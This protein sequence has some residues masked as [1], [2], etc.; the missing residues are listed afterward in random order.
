VSAWVEELRARRDVA[1]E[2]LD[3]ARA[4]LG[5]AECTAQD[6]LE[7]AEEHRIAQQLALSELQQYEV[8][9][10]TKLAA[11]N[12]AYAHSLPAPPPSAPAVEPSPPVDESMLDVAPALA[13]A[14]NSY[15]PPAKLLVTSE[16]FA[17]PPSSVDTLAKRVAWSGLDGDDEDDDPRFNPDV[18]PAE[19]A[20]QRTSGSIRSRLS[21]YL[22]TKR[23]SFE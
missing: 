22:P 1:S 3:A 18:K 14:R 19:P 4:T 7:A 12:A 10:E 8:S 16:R 5:A 11:A 23:L 20:S 21:S 17:K 9:L 2:I 13:R 15:R 6:R